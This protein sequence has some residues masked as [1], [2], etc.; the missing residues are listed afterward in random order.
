MTNKELHEMY[1]RQIRALGTELLKNADKYAGPGDRR[2]TVKITAFL[3]PDIKK[4]EL[5]VTT[6]TLVPVA[7]I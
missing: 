6:A 7:D 4:P 1:V 5:N 3:D 2:V